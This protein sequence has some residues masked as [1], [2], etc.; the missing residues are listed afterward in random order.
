MLNR[1]ASTRTGHVRVHVTIKTSTSARTDERRAPTIP[2]RSETSLLNDDQ[3]Y[4]RTKL[5]SQLYGDS[6]AVLIGLIATRR[7]TFH[8]HWP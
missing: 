8:I 7:R 4:P 6:S 3:A 5:R 1:A 2:E